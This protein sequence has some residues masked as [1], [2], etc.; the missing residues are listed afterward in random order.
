M[1][2][3]ITTL[4]QWTIASAGG[5]VVIFNE[6]TVQDP[7][8]APEDTEAEAAFLWL[9]SARGLRATPDLDDN[10]EDSTESIGEERFKEY[11]R[12]KTLSCTAQVFGQTFVEAHDAVDSI[13]TVMAP[14]LDTGAV[15]GLIITIAPTLA[16]VTDQSAFYCSCRSFEA[17]ENIVVDS[18]AKQP[19]PYWYDLTF[20]LRMDFP[21]FFAWDGDSFGDPK[22]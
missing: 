5:D 9:Q 11:G 7:W 16:G 1:S 14:D 12:G 19:S 10:R 8:P 20:D 15:Q 22:W 13:L 17:V 18:A 21:Q 4:A 2:R 3:L 6:R